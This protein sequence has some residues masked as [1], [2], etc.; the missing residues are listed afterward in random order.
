MSDFPAGI[1]LPAISA[2]RLAEETLILPG[3]AT[4]T[5]PP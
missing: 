2:I 3:C 4:T 5:G 1:R